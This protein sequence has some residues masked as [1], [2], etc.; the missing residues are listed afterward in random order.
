MFVK[1]ITPQ[2]KNLLIFKTLCQIIFFLTQTENGIFSYIK[3]RLNMNNNHTRKIYF[4]FKKYIKTILK[5]HH[6]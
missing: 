3:L 1:K 2:L 4:M 6:V 5:V